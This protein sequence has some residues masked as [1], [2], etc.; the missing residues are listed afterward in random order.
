MVGGPFVNMENKA[1][2]GVLLY[3]S[4]WVNDRWAP[5]Q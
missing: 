3:R 5:V 1:G 2:L 4:A